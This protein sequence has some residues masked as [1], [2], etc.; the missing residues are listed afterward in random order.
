MR[1]VGGG[2]VRAARR[3]RPNDRSRTGSRDFECVLSMRRAERERRPTRGRAAVHTVG[4]PIGAYRL[5]KEFRGK[6]AVRTRHTR[7]RRHASG[8]CV[9]Q[10]SPWEVDSRTVAGR[11]T[12]GR[13]SFS[14]ECWLGGNACEAPDSAVAG[15]AGRGVAGGNLVVPMRLHGAWVQCQLGQLRATDA[16]LRVLRWA[17]TSK[18]WR[19]VVVR[20]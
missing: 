14:G 12:Y 17:Y 13:W 16:D 20:T 8:D 4:E 10:L 3:S 9:Q 19:V 15:G 5:A 11:K 1:S 7:T 2:D 6:G 18:P